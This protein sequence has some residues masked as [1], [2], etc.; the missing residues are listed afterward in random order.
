[1]TPQDLYELLLTK[2]AEQIPLVVT[3]LGA[4]VIAGIRWVTTKIATTKIATA[5]EF[6]SLERVKVQ[7][8]PKVP[9]PVKKKQAMEA[10]RALHP[11]VRPLTEKGRSKAI[12]SAL[13]AARRKATVKLRESLKP[14]P[15]A[16][17][18]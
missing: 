11:L 7:H 16:S 6:E 1:M 5:I 18:R 12:E 9:G 13:P 8:L 3:A 15:P 4:L 14:P 10:V 2:V 17:T